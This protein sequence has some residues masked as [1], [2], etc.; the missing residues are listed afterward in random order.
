MNITDVLRSRAG[1]SRLGS[2]QGAAICNRGEL[3]A[4]EVREVLVAWIAREGLA[5]Q[6]A[7]EAPVIRNGCLGDGLCGCVWKSWQLWNGLRGSVWENRRLWDGYRGRVAGD[8]RMLVMA[9]VTATKEQG[10]LTWELDSDT[11]VGLWAGADSR[12]SSGAKVA[13]S[14]LD[15]EMGL[16]SGAGAIS[17]LWSGAGGVGLESIVAGGFDSAGLGMQAVCVNISG[18]SA[19][20][21]TSLFHPETDLVAGMMDEDSGVAA[22]MAEDSGV[23]A[24]T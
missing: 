12:L 19:M 6:G 5:V 9:I 14:G 23:V 10:E 3:E 4:Q 21:D 24:M 17:G 13:D 11:G 18:G 2:L 7:R 15:S 16:N 8:M 1:A 20:L 22:M